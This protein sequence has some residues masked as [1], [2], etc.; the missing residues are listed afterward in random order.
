VT[1]PR[2][3]TGPKALEEEVTNKRQDHERNDRDPV[4][5]KAQKK[6]KMNPSK[7]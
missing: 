4:R 1:T 2:K 5:K 7:S 3:K 6:D